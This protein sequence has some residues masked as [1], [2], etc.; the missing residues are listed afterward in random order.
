MRSH[1]DPNV[2]F[3]ETI[4]LILPETFSSLLQEHQLKPIVHPKVEVGSRDPLTLK[5]IF[6]E[7]PDVKLKGVEK[8]NVEKKEPKVDEK[9]VERMVQYL[10]EQQKKTSEVDRAAKEGDQVEMNFAGSDEAGKEIE[11]TVATGYKA[12]IGSG[13]L[14]PGFEDALKGL[15][16][17][18]RKTFTLKFP[19]KYQAEH[20]RNKPVTFAVTVTKVE[21]VTMPT[22]TDAFAKQNFGEESAAALRTK[23]KE[24]M[25]TQEERIEEQRREQV[26]LEKI[27]EATHVEI[28]PEL[29]D[30]EEQGLIMEL[31][32]QLKKQ[33]L[34]LQ[35]WINQ[36]QKKPEQVQKEMRDRAEKRLQLRFG[37]GKLVDEKEARL[38]DDQMKPVLEEFLNSLPP[39]K[40]MESLGEIRKGSDLYER[41]KWQREV[42]NTIG[43]MLAV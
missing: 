42:E 16:K 23:I 31:Q 27:R 32:D 12:V 30:E 14:I 26:L 25:Q 2:L 4:R 17:G 28:A 15:K 39:E 22:L 33:N 38:T 3:E 43:K 21:E 13:S 34:T 20:L 24:Q 11:G 35:D 9:D 40:R 10:L 5:I 37:L 41:L 6:V 1:L 36:S 7:K 29:V 8:I 19:E 18:D